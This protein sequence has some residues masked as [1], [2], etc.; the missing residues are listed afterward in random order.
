MGGLMISSCQDGG[1]VSWIIN[2]F[3]SNL[4]TVNL[5]LDIKSWPFYK[6]MKRFILNL[7]VKRFQMLSCSV[8]FTLTLTLGYWY[9][10]WKV[11]TRNRG[12]NLKS[13]LCTIPLEVGISCKACPFLS[14]D[15]FTI[16]FYVC[17]IIGQTLLEKVQFNKRCSLV[18]QW[19]PGELVWHLGKR[20]D[21]N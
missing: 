1:G 9:I 14:G 11:K 17:L 21:Y 16:G 18:Y 20:M 5:H 3:S 6:I 19:R 13:T 4:K 8:S 2:A 12:M 7:F 10:M 15:V